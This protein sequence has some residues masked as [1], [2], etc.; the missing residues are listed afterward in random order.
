[1][2]TLICLKH[3]DRY[4]KYHIVL[5]LLLFLLRVITQ[6]PLGL[7]KCLHIHV[8]VE[9]ENIHSATDD[10]DSLSSL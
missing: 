9:V 3:Q 2:R 7:T 4:L 1:M 6:V 8:H 5:E 10:P